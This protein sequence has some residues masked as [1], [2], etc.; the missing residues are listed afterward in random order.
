MVI[1]L[2]SRTSAAFL[3]ADLKQA[4]V[5][6]VTAAA[7][8]AFVERIPVPSCAPVLLLLLTAHETHTDR[9][10][11]EPTVPLRAHR[12]SRPAVSTAHAPV[13]YRLDAQKTAS[14]A[15]TQQR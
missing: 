9:V 15:Q 12:F 11:F 6:A 7:N 8:Q 5:D 1:R 14:D 4:R 13:H 10:G 2:H 3:A